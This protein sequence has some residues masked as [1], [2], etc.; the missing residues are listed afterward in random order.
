MDMGAQETGNAG[1]EPAMSTVL[2]LAAAMGLFLGFVLG[3]P[4]WRVLQR[5]TTAPGCGFPPTA[6]PGRWG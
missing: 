6:L 5:L 3:Y 1:Q 4:Q 2:L